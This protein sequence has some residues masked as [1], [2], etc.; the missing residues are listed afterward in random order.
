MDA[1]TETKL[2]R[3]RGM[4]V[5]NLAHCESGSIPAIIDR[6]R[7]CGITWLA[8]KAGDHGVPWSQFTPDL[9]Q[10]LHAAGLKVFGWSY[11]LPGHA[12]AQAAVVHRVKLCGAD[13]FVSDSEIEWDHAEHPD[14]EAYQYGRALGDAAP[15]F[16]VFD[17][18]W[19][20]IHGHQ[21][22]PFSAFGAFVAARCPQVYWIERSG[23][24]ESV[25]AAYAADWDVYEAKPG[26]PKHPHYPSGSLY[27]KRDPESHVI[28]RRCAPGDVAAF[29]AAA[30]MR[31][32]PGVLHWEWSQ[33]PPDVWAAFES[34][35][36]P[37]WET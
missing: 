25:L 3:G 4:Y 9:V 19:P 36:I 32:C 10:Q 12:E 14:S 2:P 21:A 6:C 15:G 23:S 11:D 31:G 28:V 34:G 20:G 27:H 17:A 22:F 8:I 29:E 24:V 16:T 37:R 1:T 33:V 7:K 26:H 13:G 5:W 30:Q 35:E 18:P